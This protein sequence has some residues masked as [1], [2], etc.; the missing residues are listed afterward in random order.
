MMKRWNDRGVL[1]L[2]AA[3]GRPA[4][5]ACATAAAQG[6]HPRDRRHDRRRAAKEGR[7]GYKAGPVGRSPDQGRAGHEKLAQLPG[8]QIASIGSQDMN[9]EVWG[10]LARRANEVLA[11]PDVT[12]IVVTH[13]T[14]T[15]EETA[16]FLGLVVR[17]RQTRRARRSMRPATSQS[18]DGPLNLYNAVAVAADKDAG[19]RGVLVVSTTTSTARRPQ[20]AHDGGADLRLVQSRPDRPGVLRRSRV[21]SWPAHGTRPRSSLSRD[22]SYPRVDIV[23]AHEGV[24]GTMVKAA[25]AAGAKGSCWRVWVTATART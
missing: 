14:D 19:G 12:G 11:Q 5:A 1:V 15:M 17:S 8:E 7:P 21:L 4:A 16:F 13:G 20:D 9:D 25:I 18:A 6:R 23:Y 22:T 2:T 10:K 3:V 24:D